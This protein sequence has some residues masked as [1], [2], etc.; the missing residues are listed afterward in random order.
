ME[1]FCRDCCVAICHSCVATNHDGHA[2]MLLEEAANER[3]VKAKLV[4]EN[5]KKTASERRREIA[6]LDSDCAKIQ[7]HVASVKKGVQQ[8]VDNMMAVMEAQKQESFD[9]LDNR[10]AESMQRLKI[11][12]GEIENQVKITETEIGATEA[13]LQRNISTEIM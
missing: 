4:L 7:D 10:A 5:Q 8:F 13:I 6:Q 9:Y 1:F 11:Q 12:R 2:K 3:K